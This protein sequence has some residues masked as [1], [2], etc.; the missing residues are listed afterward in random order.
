MNGA[1]RA[2]LV[3]P[4]ELLALIFLVTDKNTLT[5][6][7]RVSKKCCDLARD[8]LYGKLGDLWPV[9]QFLQ[10]D[11]GNARGASQV[12]STLHNL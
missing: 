8:V 12:C 2:D 1:T 4:N 9:L 10:V 5:V 3:L 7:A 6:I 11:K